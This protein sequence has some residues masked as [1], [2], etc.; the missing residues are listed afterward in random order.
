MKH[1]LGFFRAVFVL[2]L[3]VLYAQFVCA[4]E[5]SYLVRFNG[6][7][8]P[9]LAAS[10]DSLTEIRSDQN[11]YVIDS[12]D[13]LSDYERFGVEY[14]E[15]NCSV[16][17]LGEPAWN[18][19]AIS[20]DAAWSYECHGNEIR[21]GLIDSGVFAHPSVRE[22]LLPGWNFISN[23]EDTTDTNG[24]GTFV[25]GILAASSEQG[26][27][28][29]APRLRIVPLKC[30]DPDYETDVSLIAA[31]IYAAVDEFDCQVIN[32]SFGS[33]QMTITLQNAVNYALEKG[34]ILVAAVGNDG[35]VTR[36]YPAAC[37]GVIGVGSIDRAGTVSSS[38]QRNDTVD[39]VAP[40]VNIQSLSLFGGTS[41]R[42]GTS[43]ATP[44]I[45]AMAALAL[46]ADDTLT[47]TQ[48]ERLLVESAQDLGDPGYDFTYGHG[49]P[50]MEQI[51]IALLSGVDY[52][53]SPINIGASGASTTIFNLSGAEAS[54][55][56]LLAGYDGEQMIACAATPVVLIEGGKETVLL[57]TTN[58]TIRHFLCSAVDHRPIAKARQ[59]GR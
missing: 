2:G 25:S 19:S 24:H 20:A 8:S 33:Q 36:Y 10:D 5:E 52:F 38:S 51:M 55:V 35:L 37:E 44:H 14:V 53:V 21:V 4:A 3:L 12:L 13:S 58:G 34:V 57:S 7:I 49:R 39:V 31:A 56:S 23:T 50:D 48:F 9:Q 15:P 28:G 47:P 46:S 27:F 42:S 43:F 40:G 6:Q 54:V 22:R 1:L 26:E 16:E 18:V 41:Y 59:G 45:A 17:L 29:V 11:L 32:M 30:F